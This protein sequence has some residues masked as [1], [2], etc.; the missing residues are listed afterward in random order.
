MLLRLSIWLSWKTSVNHA[1]IDITEKVRNA[2]DTHKFAC[3]VFVYFQKAFDNLNHERL[4][5]KLKYYGVSSYL[6]NR[7]QFVS[8]LDF[9]S[10]TKFLKH[11]VPQGSVRGPL[12]FLIFFNELNKCIKYSKAYH[13]ADDTK[14]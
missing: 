9:D 4:I 5:E 10:E 11:G 7:S 8:I 1:L 2:L 13:C 14:Y 3:G 12:L 6:S